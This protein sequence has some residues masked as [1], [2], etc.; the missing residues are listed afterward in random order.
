MSKDELTISQAGYADWLAELELRIH[1][2]QHAPRLRPVASWCC[3]TGRLAR[4]FWRARQVRAGQQGGGQAGPRSTQCLAEGIVAWYKQ[5]DPADHS[6]CVLCDSA[7]TNDVTKT[8]RAVILQQ[9]GIANVL[10]LLGDK[11]CKPQELG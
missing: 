4:T 11:R 1:A 9:H 10:S 8:N 6:T 2:A 5:L 7:F 3:C